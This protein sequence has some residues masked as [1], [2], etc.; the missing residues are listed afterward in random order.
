MIGAEIKEAREEQGLTVKQVS[1]VTSIPAPRITE[2][3]SGA[4]QPTPQE[5]SVLFTA[6]NLL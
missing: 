6:L 5:L 2:F 4:Q 3:E 1:E